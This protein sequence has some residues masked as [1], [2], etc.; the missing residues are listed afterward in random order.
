[1]LQ[2][3]I[4]THGNSWSWLHEFLF[5][6]NEHLQYNMPSNANLGHFYAMQSLF[7]LMRKKSDKYSVITPKNRKKLYS[8]TFDY[9]QI[10]LFKSVFTTDIVYDI[11]MSDPIHISYY[12]EWMF[13][14]D[15]I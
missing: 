15:K 8:V 10:Y 1:M 12:H 6:L 9:Y 13:I 4:K 3:T 2:I 5:I 7:N 11:A 14:L